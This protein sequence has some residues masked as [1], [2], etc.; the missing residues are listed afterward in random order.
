MTP[1]EFEKILKRC[2]RSAKILRYSDRYLQSLK[3]YIGTLDFDCQFKQGT[4][5]KR[6]GKNWAKDKQRTKCC[7]VHCAY[8]VGYLQVLDKRSLPFYASHF[9]PKLG[10]WR[11]KKGCILPYKLRSTT[12]VTYNCI[13]HTDEKVQVLRRGID[14]MAEVMRAYDE[15]LKGSRY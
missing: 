5:K 14:G 11:P 1:D 3:E 2:N 6:R 7:C 9:N 13:A 8:S 10:F 12:C 4:C 15:K